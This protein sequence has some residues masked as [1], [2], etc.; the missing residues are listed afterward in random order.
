MPNRPVEIGRFAKGMTN[1]GMPSGLPEG[2]CRNAVNADFYDDG[3]WRRRGGR[4]L[5]YT[6]SDADS[7]WRGAGM[8][9][10]RDGTS[11]KELIRAADGTY[12]SRTVQS[13]LA[14]RRALVYQEV[15]G[16]VYWTNGIA[17]GRIRRGVNGPWGVTPPV[18]QPALSVTSSGGLDAGLYLVAITYLDASGQESGTG[19]AEQ[20]SV[21]QGGGILASA[22]PSPPAGHRI[23]LYC[24]PSDGQVLYLFGEYPAAQKEV[25]IERFQGSIPLETQFGIPPPAGER[26]CAYN[27]RI[28]IAKGSVLHATCPLRYDLSMPAQ[29][30]IPFEHP[31]RVVTDVTDGLYVAT[32]TLTYFVTGL[33]TDALSMREVLPYGAPAGEAVELPGTSARVWFSHRGLVQAGPQGQIVTRMD[34]A[35]AVSRFAKCLAVLYRESAGIKQI[36]ATLRSGEASDLAAQDYVD[37]ELAR[38]GSAV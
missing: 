4:R 8:T 29:D 10:Y 36:V 15:A 25:K 17:T 24:S 14:P 37:Y 5:V 28:Y 7:L 12:T 11:L 32:D 16:E 26:L 30:D 22:I 3:R 27:G 38:R 1:L 33:D 2:A 31:I 21:P 35:V 6:S 23:A 13:G 34:G 9:L 20:V 19:L 18:Q